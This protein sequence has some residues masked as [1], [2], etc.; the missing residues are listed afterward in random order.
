L[1]FLENMDCEFL[2]H[3][4]RMSAWDSFE[5]EIHF[6]TCSFAVALLT[7]IVNSVSVSVLVYPLKQDISVPVNSGVP[8]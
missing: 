4:C 7:K 8:Y 5:F 2:F 1:G 6:L 3:T